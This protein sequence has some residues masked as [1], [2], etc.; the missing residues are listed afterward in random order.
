[1]VAKPAKKKTA[2]PK[3]RQK[4]AAKKK[5]APVKKT[6]AAG[7]AEELRT[8]KERLRHAKAETREALDQQNA[9]AEILRIISDS[10]HDVQPVSARRASARRR[11]PTSSWPKAK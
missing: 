7:L 5:A 10:P 2:Q 4:T 11:S 1:M 8:A 9:T 3:A 6:D